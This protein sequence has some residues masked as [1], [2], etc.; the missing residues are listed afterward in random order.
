MNICDANRTLSAEVRDFLVNVPDA[1]EESVTDYL[2]WKWRDLDSRFKCINIST[3]TRNEENT[4]TGADFELELWLVGKRSHFP[5]VFQAKKFVKPHDSYVA[6][7]NY[8]KGTQAQ[9][10]KLIAY[11]KSKK[12]LPFYAFYSI[13]DAKTQTKCRKP[14]IQNA[15]IFISDAISIMAFADGAHGKKISK[16]RI[17]SAAI[18]FHCIFCCPLGKLGDFFERHFP[19][20]ADIA[21]LVGNEKLPDYVNLLRSGQII[22]MNRQEI[23][24]IINQQELRSFR[25]IGVYEM[26]ENDWA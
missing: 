13:P 6:K 23:L 2:V 12:R 21:E 14:D 3:F 22:G 15:G 8:P 4:V 9:L 26:G 18:P 10:G 24:S 17:L 11:S 1:K 19:S 20:I 16:N 5:L 7:L 25:T